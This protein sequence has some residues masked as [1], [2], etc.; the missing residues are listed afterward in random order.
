MKIKKKDEKNFGTLCLKASRE[1]QEPRNRL[2]AK[3]WIQKRSRNL[4]L[5]N[6]FFNSSKLK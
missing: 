4:S 2:M 1:T 5:E 6:K 3:K